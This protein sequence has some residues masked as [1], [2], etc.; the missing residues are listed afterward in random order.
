M[1]GGGVGSDSRPRARG[2]ERQRWRR[3]EGA[4]REH[5]N[6]LVRAGGGRCAQLFVGTSPTT[7]TPQS[8]PQDTT[9][10]LRSPRKASKEP[11][12]ISSTELP[13]RLF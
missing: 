9:S 10:R 8:P 5:C 11:A 3:S 6:V 7:T 13:T 2:G 1:V 4:S 12:E